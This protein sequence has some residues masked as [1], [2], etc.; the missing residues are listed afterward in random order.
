MKIIR[1][2][3][4][5]L[6][7]L[8]D[9]PWDTGISPPELLEFIATH[10]PGT[11]LDLGCGTG[12]NAITLAKNQW[13]VIGIDF[14]GKAIQR[15]KIKASLEKV[16]ITFIVGDVT[17]LDQFNNKFDLVLDIGC[18]HSLTK[19]QKNKYISNLGK[20]IAPSGNFLL[21]AWLSENNRRSSGIS[22]EDIDQIGNIL[23]KDEFQPGTERGKFP[24]AWFR[25]INKAPISQDQ[26]IE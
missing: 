12:T 7:Y 13:E 3:Y 26:T 24:S 22:N 19:Y 20:I 23:W 8:K 5:S 14:I 25:F 1:Q 21:Y 6:L 10:P 4:Y 15:A 2:L 9:P 18:F 16:D 17:E 11:A